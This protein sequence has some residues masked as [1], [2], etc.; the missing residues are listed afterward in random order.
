M[1]FCLIVVNRKKISSDQTSDRLPKSRTTGMVILIVF[2]FI[3][4]ELP[5]LIDLFIGIFTP[6]N[7]EES[8]LS[9]E[10][11]T[12]FCSAVLALSCLSNIFIYFGMSKQFR[13]SLKQMFAIQCLNHST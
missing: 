11:G 7:D 4:G 12:C 3:L 2:T 13:K 5:T 10:Y 6:E 1:I 8:W 9:S